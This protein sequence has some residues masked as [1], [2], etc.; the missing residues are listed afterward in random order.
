M[1]NVLICCLAYLP[2]VLLTGACKVSKTTIGNSKEV[3]DK[4]VII[5]PHTK[6][7]SMT[8]GACHGTCPI[9]TMTVYNDGVINL[10]GKRFCDKLGPH[11]TTLSDTE[12][13]LLQQKISLMDLESM[14]EKIESMVPDFPS[15]ELTFTEKGKDNKSIW[16]RSGAPDD[17]NELSVILD[18]FRTSLTWKVDTDAPLPAGIIEN[19]ML[20]HLKDDVVASD[21]TKQYREFNLMPTKEVT[22]DQNYWLFTFDTKKIS[23]IEMLNLLNKSEQ[24]RNA[25]FNQ[26]LEQRH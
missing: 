16:W 21:F 17:I 3:K 5:K 9:Y 20:V 1:K 26:V 22:P 4:V 7:V 6:L 25:E 19:Q 8:K 13:T 10:D 12:L 23:G 24:V 14:P 2:L 15:T 11:T 18:K